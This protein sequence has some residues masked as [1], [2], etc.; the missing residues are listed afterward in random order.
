LIYDKKESVIWGN[1]KVSFPTLGKRVGVP[2]VARP[3]QQ[4]WLDRIIEE[5]AKQGT[6]MLY[7]KK[8][9][10]DQPTDCQLCGCQKGGNG[11]DSL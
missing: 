11:W 8:H 7:M 1:G 5:A 6:A 9:K 4:K 10:M 2:V 3:Y